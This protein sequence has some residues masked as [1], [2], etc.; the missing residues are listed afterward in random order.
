MKVLFVERDVEY[1]DPMNVMLL[2]A[3]ARQRGHQTFLTILSDDDLEDELRRIRPDVVAFSAKTGE[4]STYF[5]ANDAVTALPPSTL[6][7]SQLS[8]TAVAPPKT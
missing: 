1:I 8:S 4:H 5:R 7:T 3:L 6:R 2:S